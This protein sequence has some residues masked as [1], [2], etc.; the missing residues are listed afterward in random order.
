MLNPRNEDRLDEIDS[1]ILKNEDFL[2]RVY[3]ID[4]LNLESMDDDSLSDPYIQLI[5][6]ETKIHVIFSIISRF[7]SFIKN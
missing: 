3:V 5:L 4:A 1:L 2:V 7:F 6:G